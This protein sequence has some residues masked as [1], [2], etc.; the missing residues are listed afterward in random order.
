MSSNVAEQLHLFGVVTTAAQGDIAGMRNPPAASSRLY[1]IIHRS[2]HGTESI[3]T[4]DIIIA[5]IKQLPN[6]TM[7]SLFIIML[8]VLIGWSITQNGSCSSAL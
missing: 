3:Y 5:V 4:L 8:S 2:A 6:E 1:V 7:R